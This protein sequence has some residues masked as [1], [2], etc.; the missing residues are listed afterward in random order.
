M[1]PSRIARAART[2]S[3]LRLRATQK[4]RAKCQARF[5]DWYMYGTYHLA[6]HA[7]TVERH[8]LHLELL[9]VLLLVREW[10]GPEVVEVRQA[11]HWNGDDDGGRVESVRERE[12]E[13]E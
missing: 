8:V 12:S 2:P 1:W 4:V 11:A 6:E 9:A 5:R 10:N 13:S 7:S 3:P